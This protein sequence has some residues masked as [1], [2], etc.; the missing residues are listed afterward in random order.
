MI[1]I[2][3]RGSLTG[4]VT[5]HGVQGHTA[6]PH[7]A[8][9]PVHRLV[10][11]LDAITGP[12][13]DNGTEHFQPSTLQLATVDV[14]NTASNV[15]PGTARATFNARFNDSWSGKDLEAWVREQFDGAVGA[16][17]R[18]DLEVRVSGESFICPPGPLSDAIA[19]AAEAELG[20]RPELSTTGGTSD[21]RFIHKYC[22]VAEFGA[23]GKTMHKVDEQQDVAD[24]EALS[25]I[26]RRV[27]D[28][29]FAG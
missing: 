6:Y 20:R 11:M 28:R 9:N 16:G 3:R 21:A 22:P 29:I 7:L 13:L 15:I 10:K 27:L 25:R 8:D 24:L 5:V 4:R 2:G 12:P 19:D 17:G 14:G 23:V 18:Y 1:K 26:Y